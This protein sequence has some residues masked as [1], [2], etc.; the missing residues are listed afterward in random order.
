MIILGLAAFFVSAP[1]I[2]HPVSASQ[3]NQIRPLA[4]NEAPAPRRLL[5]RKPVFVEPATD[6][7][8]EKPTEPPVPTGQEKPEIQP[9]SGIVI[10]RLQG[11]DP[12]NVGTIDEQSGGFDRAMWAGTPL[13][14]AA[15]LIRQLPNRIMSPTMRDLLRRL[16]L[17]AAPPPE[18]TEGQDAPNLV[19]LRVKQ[20]Q[21]MGLLGSASALLEIAPDRDRNVD[22]VQFKADNHLLSGDVNSAC[23]ETR[24]Q[25]VRL[26]DPYWQQL[27][28]FCQVVEGNLAEASL[29]ASLLAEGGSPSDPIFA[30]LAD[31]LISGNA[32][33]LEG[34]SAH[35]PLHGAMMHQA[36]IVITSEK[37]TEVPTSFLSFIASNPDADLDLRLSAA[38]RSVRFGAM[39]PDR[40]K[41]MYASAPFSGEDLENALSIADAV[42]SPRG[43]ALL[44][45][46]AVAQEVPT[47]RAGVLQ[48]ALVLA[49]EDGVY[50]FTIRLYRSMLEAMAPSAELS[51]FAG[52]AAHALFAL[53]RVDLARAWMLE[54]RY[55]AVRDPAAKPVLD[56]LWALGLLSHIPELLEK[57]LGTPEAWRAAVAARAPEHAQKR[58]R[59]AMA[60]LEFQGVYTDRDGWRRL[61]S[62]NA[63]HTA[64]L[65][66]YA[67]R[68][69]LVAAAESGRLGELVLLA[70]ILIGDRELAAL[71]MTVLAEVV[72]ALTQAGLAE[73]ARALVLE[74][75]IEKGL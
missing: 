21:A 1:L 60:L 4:Q 69:A 58:I 20:L 55:A 37:L 42:R 43:R 45:Q 35:T 31:A 17:T 44:F 25:D 27:L 22:L 57:P 61:L 14:L 65:P 63:R 2:V 12:E 74:V 6:E 24:R 39:T 62:D 11:P 53:G 19:G 54:L 3:I 9:R 34:I 13:P 40:L 51:W 29:G 41:S 38:E 33:V 10:N 59:D 64:Q 56:S 15:S 7:P 48:K 26:Q 18:R 28:I 67:H 50:A 66:S 52:E 71:E 23:A 8:K 75:A 30:S 49:Q 36:K 73:E 5:P 46:A 32:P 16:L 70:V 72:A 68:A 47:A